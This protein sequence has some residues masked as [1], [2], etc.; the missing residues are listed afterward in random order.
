MTDD[1]LQPSGSVPGPDPAPPSEEHGP[2]HHHG[3]LLPPE[4][5]HP[6]PFDRLR[7]H[8]NA[9]LA[10]L[11]LRDE[12]PDSGTG[13]DSGD[14]PKEFF[15]GPPEGAH[16]PDQPPPLPP[17]E[18]LKR[19]ALRIALVGG[20][21]ALWVGFIIL[22]ILSHDLPRIETLAD[23]HPYTT[24]FVYDAD[25]KKVWEYFKEQRTVLKFEEIP[26]R[27]RQAFIAAEDSSFYSHPG[28]D[29]VGILRAAVA[30]FLAGEIKQGA[31]T[32]T[33][34]VA[35]SFF[36]TPERQLTR[37]IK[38][39]ILAWRIERY[40]SKDEILALY[41]NQIYLGSG[42]HGIAAA[43]ETYFRKPLAELTLA[44]TAT[45]AG[46]APRP[47]A[48]A[49]NVNPEA[50]R[51]RREYVLARMLDNGFITKAEHDEA[52]AAEVRAFPRQLPE[53]RWPHMAYP[54]EHLRQELVA[55]LGEEALFSGS[56]R[57]VTSLKETD[58]V[59]AA[60]ALRAGIERLDQGIGY[61]GPLNH[62]EDETQ[63]ADWLAIA[64]ETIRKSWEK[65]SP[66][67][68]SKPPLE[69]GKTYEALVTGFLP[70]YTGVELS[71]SESQRGQIALENLAWAR[72]PNPDVPPEKGLIKDPR[73]AVAVGDVVLVRVVSAVLK[74]PPAPP[75]GKKGKAPPKPPAP[76]ETKG[77]AVPE[78]VYELSLLQEPEVQ[79][80]LL[81][82]DPKT[83]AIRAMVGGYD[84][85]KSPFNRAVQA[86]RQPGSAFKPIIFSLA[87]QNG[88][89]ASTTILDTPVVLPGETGEEYW[90]PKNYGDNFL[91]KLTLREALA[92]SVN[93]IPI[94][95]LMELGP[96][97]TIQ[98]AHELG[99]TSELTEELVL[100]LGSSSISLLELCRA[101]SVFANGGYRIEP[102]LLVE[103]RDGEGK[104]L[105]ERPPPV[106]PPSGLPE[107]LPPYL[108]A[109]PEGA[110]LPEGQPPAANGTAAAPAPAAPAEKQMTPEERA[111]LLQAVPV[112]ARAAGRVISPATAF[113]VTNLLR[114]VIQHGTGHEAV[115]IGRPAAGKTGT[116]ND[117]ID[118]WFVGY[119]PNLLAGVWLG[120]DDRRTLGRFN[121]G[122]NTAAPIWLSYM[123]KS[124]QGAPIEDFPQPPGIIFRT[125][126]AKTGLLANENT[127]WKLEQAYIEGSEPTEF[128]RQEGEVGVEDFFH[129][130]ESLQENPDDASISADGGVPAIP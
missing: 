82:L 29:F 71:L 39:A 64:E 108:P 41:L 51:A 94:K 104:S 66:Q 99:I 79:G 117:N 35:R 54:M 86:Y 5:R 44:E 98:Y 4:E 114:G 28:I 20:V 73:K 109:P 27:M 9:L 57:V 87:L 111:Q 83:G 23:Y 61:R 7:K 37:K 105:Y 32:I 123:E 122:G 76:E 128:A 68:A 65:L 11:G 24:T 2:G 15:L 100:A 101:F 8:V 19:R 62:F 130:D 113:V 55:L 107:N 91:G 88:Y 58:Q 118:N 38:E 125:V 6:S 14:H 17:K 22:R 67:E 63:R 80:A 102:A 85:K 92:R 21:A 45:L 69:P 70:K 119:T 18:I 1:P 110:T 30:N 96:Q 129:V 26:E 124:V 59:A 121:A 75:K 90:K 126:D 46:V 31:S 47:S 84:F 77:P 40:L 52:L 25:G 72:A 89:T 56:L 60:D 95:I 12:K 49:P 50:A 53:E 81:A 36:L 103:V 34:Q 3:F 10:K 74:P 115:G 127:P 48:Y 97:K 16:P 42:A 120:Y 112:E 93:T 116:S 78:Y 13:E 106:V 33:Q 43:A